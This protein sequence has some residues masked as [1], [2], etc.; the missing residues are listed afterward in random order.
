MTVTGMTWNDASNSGTL[1]FENP[2]Y[3]TAGSTGFRLSS[4]QLYT[5]Y[6]GFNYSWIGE[7][8]AITPV[9]EPGTLGLVGFC[10][11]AGFWRRGRDGGAVE[12][13]TARR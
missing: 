10:L 11:A 7:I 9:P 8:D 1:Y 12:H 4:G 6:G 2:W 3:G 13:R 5:D